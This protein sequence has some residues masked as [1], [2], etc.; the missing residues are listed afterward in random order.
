MRRFAVIG[1][2]SFG[3]AVARELAR[4]GEHVIA[5]DSAHEKIEA[6]KD[7]VAAAVVTDA[8][9]KDNL[10]AVGVDKVDV[11]I[12]S[13]SKWPHESTLV[14]LQVSRLG[15][16]MIVAK[17]LSA[18]HAEILRRVGA[19]R[20]VFPEQDRATRLADRLAA[21]NILDY[22][23]FSA[24]LSNMNWA[25]TSDDGLRSFKNGSSFKY[26]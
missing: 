6:I 7:E 23:A 22:L 24:N 18:E 11:V 16:S 13:L 17:A 9:E 5:I 14:T 19:T 2:G 25:I 1:L 12:V 4:L 26:L 10:L 20:V 21:A 3:M 8:T 15:V